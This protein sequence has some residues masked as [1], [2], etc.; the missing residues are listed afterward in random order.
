ME[1]IPLD[2][3]LWK[4]ESI[5]LPGNDPAFITHLGHTAIE[6]GINAIA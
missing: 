6:G 4:A 1:W 5:A 3:D 2:E